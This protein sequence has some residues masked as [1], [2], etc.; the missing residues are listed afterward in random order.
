MD[1]LGRKSLLCSSKIRE[2]DWYVKEILMRNINILRQKILD[3]QDYIPYLQCMQKRVLINPLH[4][5]AMVSTICASLDSLRRVKEL[6]ALILK[7]PAT[8]RGSIQKVT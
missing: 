8:S 3:M 6:S 1:L 2:R 7:T 4:S 5:I